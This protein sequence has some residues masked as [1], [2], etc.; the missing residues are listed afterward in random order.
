M[1]MVMKSCENS[2]EQIEKSNLKKKQ[3]E[4]KKSFQTS[5]KKVQKAEDNSKEKSK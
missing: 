5:F 2:F 3:G 4:T 1:H